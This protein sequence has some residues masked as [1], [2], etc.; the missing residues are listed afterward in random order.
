MAYDGDLG[1]ETLTIG[2]EFIKNIW[3]PDTYFPNEKT[4][5]YHEATASNEFL[6]IRPTGDILRSIR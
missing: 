5:Y 1:I 4:S 2:T 6:R 3:V